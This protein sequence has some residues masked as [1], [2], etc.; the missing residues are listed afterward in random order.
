M[1]TAQLTRRGTTSPL[2]A[3]CQV[4]RLDSLA[5]VDAL[6]PAW[7]ALELH[8]PMLEFPWI[9]AALSAFGAEEIPRL[10]VARQ[11]ARLAAL[12]PL[13]G[14]RILGIRRLQFAGAS[15]LTEPMDFAWS[16]RAALAS[17]IKSLLDQRQP[18]LLDRVSAT[19]ETLAPLRRACQGR[20]II[21][22]R[23]RPGTPYLTLDESWLEPEQHLLPDHRATLRRARRQA[24]RMG[25]VSTEIHSPSLHE[26]P[27]LLDTAFE[28]EPLQRLSEVE[29]AR[30][31][32]RAVFIR[33]Y[34]AAACAAGNLRVCFLRIG[35][36][37]AAMQLA[38]ECSGSFWLLASAHR[39][40][41]NAIVTPHDSH[42]AGCW[43]DL[44]L[45]RETI[46]YAAA[47]SLDHYE[48]LGHAASWNSWWTSTSR[49]C[50]SL[51]I[52]PFGLR[53]LAAM[54]L[55]AAAAGYARWQ[56]PATQWVVAMLSS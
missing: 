37:V 14:K 24:E 5:E 4:A 50:L 35:S 1:A 23:P 54:L 10:L 38:V 43:P 2:R 34:A 3:S 29:A 6:E 32:E 40:V 12:A 31:L 21:V 18:I 20:A 11:G 47:A 42:F 13:I 56:Q 25:A 22:T 48:F 28:V 30:A 16:D 17:L 45:A 8:G 7:E 9:R 39:S 55:D 19:S 44:L 52:Y 27:E 15:E 33:H 26:L 36:R 46:A 49:P 41:P 51:R 53:S